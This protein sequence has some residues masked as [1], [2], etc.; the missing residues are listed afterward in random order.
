MYVYTPA[1]LLTWDIKLEQVPNAHP[2]KRLCI[3]HA[4]STEAVELIL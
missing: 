4:C 1:A 2:S 3:H